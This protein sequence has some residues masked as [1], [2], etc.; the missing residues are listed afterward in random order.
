MRKRIRRVVITGMGTVNPLGNSTA[1]AWQA[2]RQGVCGI[3]EITRYDTAAQKV[4]IAAEIKNLDIEGRLDRREAKKMDRYTQLA[5]IA[6]EEAFIDSG[7]D[8]AKEEAG[9]IGVMVASGIGGLGTIETEHHKGEEKGF[10]RVSPFFIPMAIANMAAGHIA[11]RFGLKVICAAVVTACAS[12][13]NAI[14]DSFRQIRDGYADAMVCGGAEASITPL[15]MGGFTS[16]KALST[17]SDPARAST[18]FDLER[19]GFVMGEGAGL[20]LIHIYQAFAAG[21]D[22]SGQNGREEGGAGED[23]QK[24]E[25]GEAGVFVKAPLVGTFY[26]APGPEAEPF[27][28]PGQ[29]VAKGQ[30]ICLIEAMKVIN[31][32]PAPRDGVILEIL[33]EDGALVGFEAPLFRLGEPSDV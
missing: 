9:R 21:K 25:A 22:L 31:E 16:M 11:I 20:S 6:A 33:A 19:S 7:L 18:P 8:M 2:A 14:G 3:G 29:K 28:K 1:D 27:V 30:T 17:S 15:G 24:P 32:I 26:Q 4:K 23:R 5:L 12:G 13:S 10:D